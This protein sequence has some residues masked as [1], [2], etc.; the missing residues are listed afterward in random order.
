LDH[1]DGRLL[2]DRMTPVQRMAHRRRLKELADRHE[3][4]A[5]EK[6]IITVK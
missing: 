5:S 2:L 3:K 6:R 1:L 4:R